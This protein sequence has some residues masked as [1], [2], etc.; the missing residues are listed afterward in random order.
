MSSAYAAVYSV[1][2]PKVTQTRSWL[3]ASSDLSGRVSADELRYLAQ[4][5]VDTLDGQEN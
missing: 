1:V 4:P 3:A 5:L 2:L